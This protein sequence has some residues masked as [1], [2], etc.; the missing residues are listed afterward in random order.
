MAANNTPTAADPLTQARIGRIALGIADGPDQDHRYIYALVKDAAKFNGGFTGLDATRTSRRR[1]ERL[2]E[3]RL[4][5]ARLRPDLA[6]ARGLERDRQGSD[7][8]LGARTAGV[9]GARVIGYCPGIQA[10]YNLW[11]PPDPTRHRAGVPTRL[12]FGL[13]EVWA[14]PTPPRARR[15]ARRNSTSSGATTPATP[16]RR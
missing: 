5:L 1:P 12:A 16:A 11:I 6:G 14:T 3:R 7:Q 10:W 4:G 15:H 2:P 9:Q 8:R 13:E